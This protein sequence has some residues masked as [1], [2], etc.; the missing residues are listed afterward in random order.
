MYTYIPI[1]RAGSQKK[2]VMKITVHHQTK[3]IIY[4]VLQEEV[5]LF[6]SPQEG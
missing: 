2:V 4:S 5:Y 6:A 3:K 1:S